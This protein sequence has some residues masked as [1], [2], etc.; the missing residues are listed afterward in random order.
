MRKTASE[1]HFDRIAPNYDS[2]KRKYS[3][4]YESLKTLLGSLI[5]A[6]KKVFEIGC[7]TGDLLI[8]LR[9]NRG[10]GMDVSSEMIKI[11]NAKN[12]KKPNV[13]FSTKWPTEKF[14]AIF[15]SDVIEH[16]DNPK[17]TFRKVRGLM[18]EKTTFVCTMANPI[19]EP[20]LMIWEKLG[21]KMVEG[22]HNRIKYSDLKIMVEETGMKITK[23][24][25]KLLMPVKIPI[26]TNLANKYL[27]KCLKRW[28][29]IEYFVAVKA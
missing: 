6:G 17:E 27:E 7:G 21:W 13:S 12:L 4:Y 11:A 24:D 15:M 8:S 3:Y 18:D 1:K 2:G 14:D 9:S 19:W 20:L 23:H 16:L 10:Y 5:P 26:L 28:A 29:F 25:H 22:P